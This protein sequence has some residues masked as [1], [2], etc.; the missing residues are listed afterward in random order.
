M[1]TSRFFSVLLGVL[2]LVFLQSCAKNVQHGRQ[3]VSSEAKTWLPYTNGQELVFETG[4]GARQT[5]VVEPRK[6]DFTHI[7]DCNQEGLKEVC[8]MYEMEQIFYAAKNDKIAIT[9]SVQRSAKKGQ[10]FDLLF[11]MLA[12]TTSVQVSMDYVVYQENPETATDVVAPETAQSLTLN[13]KQFQDVV[14][15]KQGNTAIYITK[16]QG[17]VAFQ[18]DGNLWVLQ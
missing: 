14:F 4:E 11:A 10:F 17:I 13:G 2:A 15:K 3:N 5:L 18:Y 1:K 7:Q 8:D 16:S 9:L 12:K 6:T